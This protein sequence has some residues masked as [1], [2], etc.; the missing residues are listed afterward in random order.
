MENKVKDETNPCLEKL[1][2]ANIGTIMATGDNGL[3][4][5]AVGR[6]CGII[7]S[8]RT[9]YL[10]ESIKSPNGDYNIKWVCLN[11]P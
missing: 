4:A 7:D 2:N 3:T 6:K 1:Q 9:V 5:V 11:K 10:A 8:N